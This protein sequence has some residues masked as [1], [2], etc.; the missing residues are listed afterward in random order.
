MTRRAKAVARSR[1]LERRGFSRES[2]RRLSNRGVIERA[3]RGVYLAPEAARSPHRSRLTLKGATVLA[4]WSDGHRPTRD[5]GFLGGGTFDIES[6]AAVIREIVDVPADDGLEFDG[7]GVAVESIREADEYH[8]VRVHLRATLDGASIPMQIDIGVGDIVTPPA[9]EAT[10]PTILDGFRAPRVKVYP[11]ETIIAEKLHAMVKLGIANSRMKDFFDIY[12]LAKREFDEELLAK[13]VSRTFVRRKKAIPQDA[14][15]LSSDFYADHQKQLQWRAFLRK[16]GLDAPADF[17]AV[18][19][20]LRA[21]L[22]PVMLSARN[23]R[24]IAAPTVPASPAPRVRP[25]RTRR[26][27]TRPRTRR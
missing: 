10:L 14:F 18:G 16:S 2:L 15:A 23:G 1:D 17:H 12:V 22:I 4:V 19:A 8:G 21:L 9:R 7:P 26:Q 3:S 25:G 20:V 24:I 11:P 13:A 27:S 5:L 6:A